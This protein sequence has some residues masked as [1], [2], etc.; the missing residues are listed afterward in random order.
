MIAAEGEFELFIP[1]F[2]SLTVTGGYQVPT[3]EKEKEIE[4]ISA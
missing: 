1:N 4:D 3:A 2:A